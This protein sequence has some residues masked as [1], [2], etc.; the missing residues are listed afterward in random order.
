MKFLN[1]LVI[2]SVTALVLSNNVIAKES[3]FTGNDL[4]DA[5]SSS[6]E[7]AVNSIERPN[8][9]FT[10]KNQ[11]AKMDLEQNVQQFLALTKFDEAKKPIVSLR[12]E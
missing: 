12:A 6:I 1:S 10:V 8:I 2:S 4:Q 11:I 9:Q 3:V 5:L 7:L